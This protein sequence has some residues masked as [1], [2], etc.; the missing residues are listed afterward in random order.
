MRKA[1]LLYWGHENDADSITAL[2][3]TLS[4]KQTRRFYEP[5]VFIDA[6]SVA[7]ESMSPDQH[8][9]ELKSAPVATTERDQYHKFVYKLALV[10]AFGKGGDTVTTFA[11]LR[12]PSTGRIVYVFGA[13]Q[14][15][16][17]EGNRVAKYMKRILTVIGSLGA[18]ARIRKA[19]LK[20]VL[21]WT[22]PRVEGY[23]KRALDLVTKCI[24]QDDD[25]PNGG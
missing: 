13:N 10:C 24:E 14:I 7:C 3:S 9:T 12:D 8:E 1:I 21:L 23:L 2:Q 25:Q 20:G 17:D 5:I 18:Q 6:L 19:I 15:S 11:I 4:P 16:I 22:R